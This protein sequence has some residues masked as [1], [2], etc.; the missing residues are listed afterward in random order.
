VPPKGNTPGET[1]PPDG[2]Q[3][4]LR[5]AFGR[6]RA[7]AFGLA[8]AHIELLKAE[9]GEILRQVGIIAAL[10]AG[11]LVLAI[12]MLIL[13]WVG[14]WLFVGE[15]LFGS[16]GWG[17]VHGVLFTICLIVPIGLN[18][19]GGEVRAWVRALVVSLLV[20]IGV[21]VLL[22][23]NSLH[24]AADWLERQSAASINIQREWL[25]WL[26]PG[27]FFGLVFGLISGYLLR[28]LGNAGLAG[29]FVFGFLL[30]FA[31]AGFYAAVPFNTQVAAA[32]AV[33]A[34][35]LSW[36][37]LSLWLAAR[38][39]IDPQ[40]RYENLVP[41]ESIAQFEATKAYVEQQWQRQRKNLVGR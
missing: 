34:W 11:A 30:G 26:L 6:A 22:A 10:A 40:K 35:L 3:P 33:S 4:G 18:L 2:Q 27:L 29:G 28:R 7:A 1:P 20:G 37:G 25:I 24:N 39:G 13:V 31:L 41:R 21:G 16:M 15:W 38:A 19:A 8:Q 12:L 23:T 14:S 5:A 9:L 32:F 36:I 17:I